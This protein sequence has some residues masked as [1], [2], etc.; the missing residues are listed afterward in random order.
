MGA[1][2]CPC[3][4]ALLSR[5]ST[6]KCQT[7]QRHHPLPQVS[8]PSRRAASTYCPRRRWPDGPSPASS[9]RRSPGRP[10]WGYSRRTRC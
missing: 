4:A 9:A 1:S 5:C 3:H 7:S 2:K 8:L 6:W 10:V